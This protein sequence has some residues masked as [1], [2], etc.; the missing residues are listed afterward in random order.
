MK[1]WVVAL[2]VVSILIPSCVFAITKP[3][4]RNQREI[5]LAEGS[6]WLEKVET[7]GMRG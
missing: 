7:E 2:I 6:P 3:L 5:D 4:P 1:V